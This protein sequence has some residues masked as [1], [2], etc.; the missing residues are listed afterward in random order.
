MGVAPSPV[1][2]LNRAIAVGERDGPRRGLEEIQ[3]IGDRN[4]LDRYPFLPA[5]MGSLELR[6]GNSAVALRHFRAALSLARNPTE[7]RYLEKRA[8]ACEG[9]S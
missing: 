1:V 6:R 8:R 3:A 5:A 7:R 4:R 2:A 9:G